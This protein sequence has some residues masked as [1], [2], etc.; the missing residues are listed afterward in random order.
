MAWAFHSIEKPLFPP[1][2]LTIAFFSGRMTTHI[3]NM[4]RGNIIMADGKPTLNQVK[5]SISNAETAIPF[6]GDPTAVAN[7]PIFAAYA[8]PKTT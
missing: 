5:K 2:W 7:P 1:G 3:A 6:G 8:V 4:T